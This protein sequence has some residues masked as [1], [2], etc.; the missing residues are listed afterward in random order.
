MVLLVD[1]CSSNRYHSNPMTQFQTCFF[2]SRA[3]T[4]HNG[5]VKVLT[6]NG[7]LFSRLS[8]TFTSQLACTNIFMYSTLPSRS[9]ASHT[10][11]LPVISNALT[12]A[13]AL[14]SS[15]RQPASQSL[16]A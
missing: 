5:L 1:N 16:T 13:D 7:V 14:I 2:L 4:L 6:C 11:D 9:A 12:S 8:F 15:A 10:G 3:S